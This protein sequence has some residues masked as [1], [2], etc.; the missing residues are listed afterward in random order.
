MISKN[1]LKYY[2]SLLKKKFRESEEKFIVE[3]KK[4]VYEGIESNFNCEIVFVTNK[5]A[6]EEDQFIKNLESRNLKVAVLKSVDLNKISDTKTPQGIAAVFEIKKNKLNLLSLD[7]QLLVYLEN[8]SDPGNLGTIIRTCDWFGI[9]NIFLSKESSEI[10][11]PK[12]I[13]SSMGSVFH[14]NIFADVTL[15]EITVLKKSGY[16]FLC[17]DLDGENLYDLKRGKHTLLSLANESKG[18]S[19]KLLSIIDK[20]ITIPGKGKAESLNVASASAII[21]AELTK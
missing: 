21:L 13:R 3:G 15:D 12:V 6:A 5:F 11:N 7:D 18:P 9:Q 10:F 20:K 4:S 19:E 2:S 17:G 1:E 8:I 16:E 14:V